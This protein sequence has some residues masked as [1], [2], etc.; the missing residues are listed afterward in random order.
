MIEDDDGVQA[1]YQM[2]NTTL[3]GLSTPNHLLRWLTSDTSLEEKKSFS[4][5]KAEPARVPTLPLSSSLEALASDC[6]PGVSAS[7]DLQ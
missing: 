1:G 7:C 4:P 3:D 6:N 5:H 2:C